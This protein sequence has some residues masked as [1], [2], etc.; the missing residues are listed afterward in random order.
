MCTFPMILSQFRCF[1]MLL[2]TVGLSFIAC[3]CDKYSQIL[4]F[5]YIFDYVSKYRKD[6]FL[7]YYVFQEPSV[8]RVIFVRTAASVAVD[9]EGDLMDTASAIRSSTNRVS[10]HTNIPVRRRF[11]DV[12][13][14]MMSDR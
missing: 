11:G 7:C 6:C 3:A 13:P 8:I 4:D 12:P 5:V 10:V 1:F 2:A 9:D 14:P